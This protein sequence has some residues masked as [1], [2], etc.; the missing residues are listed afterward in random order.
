MAAI[1]TN[2]KDITYQGNGITAEQK[3]YTNLRRKVVVLIPY[4]PGY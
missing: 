3:K 2:L 1:Y 4:Q